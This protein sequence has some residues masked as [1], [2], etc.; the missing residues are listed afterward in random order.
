VE[1]DYRN[2]GHIGEHLAHTLGPRAVDEPAIR[3]R[4]GTQSTEP[5]GRCAGNCVRMQPTLC[6]D[7][8]C[9]GEDAMQAIAST[10]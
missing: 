4:V 3:E 6:A 2:V 5:L 8:D 9:G 1:A 7:T 10:T